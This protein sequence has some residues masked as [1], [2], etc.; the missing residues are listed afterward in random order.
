MFTTHRTIVM[1]GCIA[2][3]SCLISLS[4]PASADL[5]VT[6]E[7]RVLRPAD[8]SQNQIG[9]TRP[10]VTYTSTVYYQ[11][12]R[13]RVERDDGTVTLYDLK[14]GR[15][16]L[17]T[18]ADKTYTSLLLSDFLKRDPYDVSS[19]L[20]RAANR[21]ADVRVDMKKDAVIEP[22]EVA[23]QQ[24]QV[25][26]L[27]G[28]IT[29]SAAPPPGGYA[30]DGGGRGGSGGGGG[31]RGGR[32]GGGGG[33]FPGGGG[34][35]GAPGGGGDGSSRSSAGPT[36]VRLAQFD[37]EVW[38]S[39]PNVLK[40]KTKIS[41]VPLLQAD[42]PSGRLVQPLAAK[43]AKSNGFPLGSKV[44]LTGKNMQSTA[45]VTVLATVKTLSEAPVDEA[46]FKIP[47][48]YQRLGGP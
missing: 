6:S 14:A 8:P 16:Y 26:D 35:G 20:S 38:L 44:T 11:G 23:G 47:T 12:D 13:A 24:A 34:G 9:E 31:G 10:D 28:N 4:L 29:A 46:L 19:D 32:R 21:P 33:G 5:T 40:S 2:S 39:A 18:T 1:T 43:I 48:D 22:K 7:V 30:G 25:Y 42:L 15:V 27:T 3:L 41:W 17:L 37:G 45:G 36:P